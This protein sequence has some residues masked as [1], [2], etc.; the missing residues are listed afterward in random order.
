MMRLNSP[1]AISRIDR[2]GLGVNYQMMTVNLPSDGQITIS[3]PDQA[4]EFYIK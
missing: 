3:H 2:L 1:Y 4:N